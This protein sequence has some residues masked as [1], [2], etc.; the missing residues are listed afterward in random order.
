[1]SD[2]L[3]IATLPA[4]LCWPVSATELPYLIDFPP[5]PEPVW[6]AQ[7][8]RI[9]SFQ[10]IDE[11]WHLFQ[12]A[13]LK[14]MDSAWVREISPWLWALNGQYADSI[15]Q[16]LASEPGEAAITAMSEYRKRAYGWGWV[17]NS[18]AMTEIGSALIDYLEFT[19]PS[20]IV[21]IRFYEWG[22]Y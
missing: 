16:A 19:N 22:K 11:G 18:H 4:G 3:E 10:V 13:A 5:T 15:S 21:V 2:A 8:S 17:A 9:T 6:R 14:L 12:D 7:C 20:E 1:M